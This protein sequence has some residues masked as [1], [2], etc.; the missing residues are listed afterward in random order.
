MDRILFPVDF[1][2]QSDR[3]VAAVADLARRFQAPVT[4]L[5]VVRLPQLR[6]EL[7]PYMHHFKTMME[8]LE[9]AFETWANE[10]LAGINV[11]RH[12]RTGDPAR[13]ITD[14]A[15]TLPADL[16]MMPTHGFTRFRPLLLGSVT[17]S[18]LHDVECPVW[19]TAHAEAVKPHTAYRSMLCAVDLA[20]STIAVLRAAHMFA[21]RYGA[22]LH[23]MHCAP[24]AQADDAVVRFGALAAEA[25]LA[26]GTP[27]D[28]VE[29]TD[30][31]AAVSAAI[32]R[33]AADL[34]IIGRG[35]LQGA[36]GR[37]RTNAHNLI[38]MSPCPVLSV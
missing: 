20:G 25:G 7:A 29:H 23:V 2:P 38:R 12:M 35:R 31:A 8:E 3:A 30:V 4:L 16:V 9:G 37:L 19:T 36:L 11:E 5:H 32:G 10:E 14:F 6:S 21:A 27:L 22:A 34:L 26:N 17:A 15:A 28:V 24:H 1:S 13:T 33:H 18:V